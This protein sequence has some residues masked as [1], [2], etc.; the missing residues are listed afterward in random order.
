MSC[1]PSPGFFPPASHDTATRPGRSF[2]SLSDPISA[3]PNRQI[4]YSQ[5][6]SGARLTQ[7]F[8]SA[9]R[10]WGGIPERETE[11]VPYPRLMH[12]GRRSIQEGV[13]QRCLPR[14]RVGRSLQTL[15][16]GRTHTLCFCVSLPRE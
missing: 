5:S 12:E 8:S 2:A 14:V 11:R 4:G 15:H 6:S 10:Q 3:S 16:S 13:P 1:C 7:P 9:R